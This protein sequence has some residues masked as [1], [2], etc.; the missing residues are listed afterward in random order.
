VNLPFSKQF[1]DLYLHWNAGFTQLPSAE[2][3]SAKHNLFTPRAAVSGIWRVRP[4]FNVM[5]ESIFEWSEEI[6]AAS[7]E[8]HYGTTV[9]PGF[10]TGWNAGQAQYIL[11]V[12]V[13]VSFSSG[14]TDTGVFGYFSYELPFS[15]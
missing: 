3:I 15:R 11:G 6:A 10:R 9:V 14:T 2:G 13:P 8:R 5:L 12:G 1:R 7:T 4:M